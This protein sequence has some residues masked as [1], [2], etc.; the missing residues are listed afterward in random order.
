MP[1]LRRL[2]REAEDRAAAFLLE[3]GLT[4]VTRRYTARGGEIDLIALDGETLVFVEVKSRGPRG[5][6]E[7]AIDDRKAARLSAAA[8]A[9]MAAMHERDRPIRFDLVA[10]TPEG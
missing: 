8:D 1:D 10:I 3:Q 6:P 4:L 7:E 5:S 9:Y 2:G